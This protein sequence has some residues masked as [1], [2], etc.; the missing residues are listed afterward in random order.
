MYTLLDISKYS[1]VVCGAWKDKDTAVEKFEDK[2]F[3]ILSDMWHTDDRKYIK[4]L[5]NEWLTKA[6]AFYSPYREEAKEGF[7]RIYGIK[8]ILLKI[9]ATDENKTDKEG[10]ESDIFSTILEKFSDSLNCEISKKTDA[11][12]LNFIANAYQGGSVSGDDLVEMRGYY[13][14][15][16][17]AREMLESILYKYL[18][19]IEHGNLKNE[20]YEAFMQK[21][22]Q[23][24]KDDNDRQNNNLD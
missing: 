1:P 13:K 7:F 11:L 12:N 10:D 20:K 23:K 14:G 8:I 2:I 22:E 6:D 21:F 16:K 4:K 18:E 19:H 5:M 3:K 9:D 15:L 24:R 17:V